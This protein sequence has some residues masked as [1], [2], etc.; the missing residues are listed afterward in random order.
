MSNASQGI[1]RRQALQSAALAAA[2]FAAASAFPLG[3][4]KAADGK[5]KKVLFFTKSSGYQHSVVTRK[6]PS[7]LAFAEKILTDLGKEH[8]F[9][10]TAT[11][12][13]SIFTPEKL[14][15]FD[16][17]AFYTTGDLDKPDNDPKITKSKDGG[18]P[19]PPDGLDALFK[20]VESGKGFIGFHCAADTFDHHGDGP[21]T[22][23]YIKFL[24]GEFDGHNK[25]QNSKIHAVKGFEPINDVND[26]EMTE[27]W[28]RFKNIAPDMQVI[29]VQETQTME[30]KV[31][32]DRK[33]YPET[34][35]RAQGK[36]RVFY[37]SMGHREDVWTNPLFQ[38]VLL[39]GLSW[40]AGNIEA[41]VKPNLKEA[42]P[43]CEFVRQ[44]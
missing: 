16:V 14:A 15:E 8:G 29:F 41:T 36:G 3:W 10:V 9:D 31:Y 12:D 7:E 27:E 26:F 1:S 22:H 44:D 40:A 23:P 21:K 24:G 28:Y 6:S 25:Q 33:P 20:F 34:W 43:D 32:K 17:I 2:A 30:E 37:T 4:A 39:G 35:A 13:G 18:V 11:K 38:Q 5:T 42:C 19:M